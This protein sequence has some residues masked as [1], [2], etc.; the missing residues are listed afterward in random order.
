MRS[1]DG[2]KD[3]LTHLAAPGLFY[4]ELRRDLARVRRSGEQLCLIRLLLRPLEPEA[5]ALVSG[6]EIEVLSFSQTLKRLSR[7]ED[8]CS[9]M[10]DLEFLTLLR[11]NGSVAMNLVKRIALTWESDLLAHA[12]PDFKSRVRLASSQLSSLSGESAL[13]FLN[14]LDLEP[15][16]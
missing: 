3:S 13:E 6:Y 14:R 5:K 8:I 2:L 1:H 4:E 10:G 11:G 15:C 7:A 12:G 16:T 9:R